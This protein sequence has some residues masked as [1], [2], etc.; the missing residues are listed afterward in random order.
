MIKLVEHKVSGL[1]DQQKRLDPAVLNLALQDEIA[2]RL[3][4]IQTLLE[5]QVPKGAVEPIE[6]L[7]ITSVVRPVVPLK[8]WFSVDIVN[9]GPNSVFVLINPEPSYEYHE[10]RLNETYRVDMHNGLIKTILFKC[11]TG[12]TA[13][14][15]LVGVL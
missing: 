13:S 3:F 15:R 11:N 4:K 2:D 10:V 14:I 6:S 5:S 1:S 12:Q 9:D 8:P 7:L